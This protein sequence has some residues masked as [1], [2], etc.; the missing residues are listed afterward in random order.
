[1]GL[2]TVVGALTGYADKLT[3]GLQRGV[4]GNI[5]DFAVMAKTAGLSIADFSKPSSEER[6][7]II[8]LQLME[9]VLKTFVAHGT[10]FEAKLGETDDL[11]SATLLS[12]RI[13]QALQTYNAELDEKMRDNLDDYIEP[14]PFIMI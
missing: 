6:L 2:G 7:F 3:E 8:D 9:V 10:S 11:V 13:I 12:L 14:M 4:S 1:M 5:L